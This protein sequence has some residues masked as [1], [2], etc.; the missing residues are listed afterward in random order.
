MNSPVYAKG[1]LMNGFIRWSMALC[2][3]CIVTTGCALVKVRQQARESLSSTVIIGRVSGS[4]SVEGPVVVAAYSKR[5]GKREIAHY[6][7]LHDWGEYELM[8][9][10]GRYYVFAF[11]DRNSNLVYD[12]GEPAG[13][14]GDP[15]AVSGPAGGVIS[16]VD[17]VIPEPLQTIEWRMGDP[18]ASEVPHKL[19]SRMAGAIVSLDDEHFAD[20]H[21]GEGFWEGLSFYKK[22][23]AN[24]F[25]LEEYD[26]QKIPILFIHG[27]G[28]TPKGWKFFVDHI[29]RTRF[30]PWFFYYPTGAR[31]RTQ[32]HQ[33]LW[34][35]VNLKMKYQ[36]D[37][38]YI[39][40][41]SMGGLV[42]RC[43]IMDHAVEFPLVKLFISLATPWG[44]DKMAEYG[45]KQS[46]AVIQSWIDMQPEGDFI[47]SL[48]REKLPEEVDFYMFYGFRGSRNPFRSNNDGTITL[49]SL[50]DRRSQAEA[51]MNYAFDE[52]HASI[53][54]SK[55]V[56]DQ[57]NTIINTHYAQ[58]STTN[59]FPGGFVKLNFSYDYP[60]GGA[61]P[62]P[63]L[64]LIDEGDLI[65][66]DEGEQRKETR[67]SLRPE[68]SG[69][70]LGP[71]PVGRY[72]V[73][74]VADN[75]K[76]SKKWVPIAIESGTTKPVDFTFTPDGTISG[77]V[78][79][80][81]KP[82]DRVAGMP[83]WTDR[84]EDNSVEVQSVKL[85]GAG[86]QRTLHHCTDA[87][88]RGLNV[89]RIDFCV[90]GY[91]R[92]FGLPAGSYQLDIRAK[93]YAP[94][95]CEVEVA[96]GMEGGVGFHNLTPLK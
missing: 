75:V 95:G 4:L 16:Y 58:H 94:Y 29:D 57:Y 6:T 10:T 56:V 36:F 32:A 69:K 60:S 55:E 3:I 15:K 20:A 84:P 59:Q 31:M 18:V 13:Q 2:L 1:I 89:S 78:T 38:L 33:L 48:Y 96:P 76:T 28:G 93:G 41:H 37:T 50:L 8:V 25:F 39:T 85:T 70:V 22:F 71:I 47:Q 19:Y 5:L 30:Q 54:Y 83:A 23:G 9:G 88:W 66:L 67:I 86:I 64:I 65:L 27:A 45:V 12:P 40:S 44:G 53:I 61:R 21:G 63:I 62:Y 91:L 52:D 92:F 43:F 77:Y 51:K 7:V 26:P 17:I 72:F 34:K 73:R 90:N 68:D 46:P 81:M 82:E 14:Y 42:A 80:E 79:S 11:N 74:L 35:L 24:I 87:S 49:S